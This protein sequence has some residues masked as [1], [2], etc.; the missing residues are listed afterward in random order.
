VQLPPASIP[1]IRRGRW[2]RY[3]QAH[4]NSANRAGFPVPGLVCA[5]A[6]TEATISAIVQHSF[7]KNV[8]MLIGFNFKVL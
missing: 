2:L 1:A 4:R 5:K 3:G 6:A 7:R 8:K